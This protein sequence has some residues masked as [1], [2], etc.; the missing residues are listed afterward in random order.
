MRIFREWNWEDGIASI[1]A[2]LEINPSYEFGLRALALALAYQGRLD[3]AK[4]SIDTAL[5]VDPLSAQVASVAGDIHGW[6]GEFETAQRLDELRGASPTPTPAAE[7]ARERYG[8]RR[9]N[10]ERRRIP[11][12]RK[13]QRRRQVRRRR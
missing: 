13:I 11:G 3:E 10:R 2:A 12:R 6:R 4:R 8:R 5:Q 1:D 7:A 9:R